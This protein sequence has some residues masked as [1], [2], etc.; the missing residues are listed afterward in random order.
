MG[1]LLRRRARLVRKDGN[2]VDGFASRHDHVK[3][4]VAVVVSEIDLVGVRDQ[5]GLPVGC[6]A[7]F[8]RPVEVQRAVR[9]V[10][11]RKICP[12]ITIEVNYIDMIAI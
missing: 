1:D 11:P 9:L 10:S 6:H 3:V 12:T 8:A 5:P 7:E 4:P 2:A